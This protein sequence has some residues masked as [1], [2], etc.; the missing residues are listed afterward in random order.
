MKIAFLIIG[1]L[2][3]LFLAWIVIRIL[4]D[5]SDEQSDIEHNTDLD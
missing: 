2:N 5:A 1:I 4:L 3:I